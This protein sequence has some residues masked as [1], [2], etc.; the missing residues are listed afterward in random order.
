MLSVSDFG[1]QG[2]KGG[3][4]GVG[5]QSPALLSSMLIDR[6]VNVTKLLIQFAHSLT[7]FIYSDIQQMCDPFNSH[8]NH[9]SDSVFSVIVVI[10][11]AAA[12]IN[13]ETSTY[14]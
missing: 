6:Y 9:V 11:V 10:V 8:E 13:H 5:R 2:G 12:V 14:I 3:G 1:R 7:P 4:V